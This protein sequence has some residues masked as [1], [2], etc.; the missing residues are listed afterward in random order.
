MSD[1][2]NV[3]RVFVSYSGRL[4]QDAEFAADLLA[5]LR[6]CELDAWIFENPAERI[7]PG[8]QIM[9][10][11]RRKI[12]DSDLVVVIVSDSSLGSEYARGE[13]EYALDQQQARGL[14]II[15]VCTTQFSRG[16][17]PPPFSKLRD[18]ILL[19]AD[20]F[21]RE[22]CECVVQ[23]VC[24]HFGNQVVE[25]V[26]GGPSWPLAGRVD[27]ELR[28]L[29]FLDARK[30]PE[31]RHRIKDEAKA[32][33]LAYRQGQLERTMTHL[34]SLLLAG[35]QAFGR[36]KLYYPQV[37]RAGLL[38]EMG[39]AEQSERA[40]RALIEPAPHP[41]LDENA[42]A[43]LAVVEL[44]RGN[45]A[46]AHRYYQDA[47]RLA[48]RR[49]RHDP[50]LCY[51]LLLSGLLIGRDPSPEL[52]ATLS[53]LVSEG[54]DAPYPGYLERI[55]A[56]LA[57]AAFCAEGCVE[58]RF[59][60]EASNHSVD[61]I[62]EL[63]RRMSEPQQPDSTRLQA[64]RLIRNALSRD[65]PE[66]S[67]IQLSHQH[68]RMLFNAGEY[69]E[70]ERVFAVLTETAPNNIQ[71]WVERAT[72]GLYA[73]SDDWSTHAR[74]AKELRLFSEVD[75]LDSAN[76]PIER[77]RNFQYYAG[78]AEFLVNGETP[79]SLLRF[80]WSGRPPHEWYGLDYY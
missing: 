75:S 22:A 8:Q 57:L 31:L 9:E 4:S 17:W 18:R 27:G 1:Q 41:L 71:F 11:C 51:G 14:P 79:E 16:M 46:M 7:R 24:E 47:E 49:G 37:A 60:D 40:F 6:D 65:I 74:R 50:D 66:S 42:Y 3:P 10:A 53:A 48:K 20:P 44:S 70:A 26:R 19:E 23:V 2:R 43:G 29:T 67:R 73:H 39:E 56:V 13:V 76:D 63:T 61:L 59:V 33:S 52:V 5:R 68:A 25:R 64:D 38:A 72:V 12:R 45:P 62:L 54:I 55:R 35:E 69:D 28:T 21:I 30:G 36:G 34:D 58:E 15:P 77:E 80:E 32:A 78:L